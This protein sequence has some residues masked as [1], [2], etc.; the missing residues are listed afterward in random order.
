MARRA[1]KPADSD[2]PQRLQGFLPAGQNWQQRFLEAVKVNGGTQADLVARAVAEWIE[3]SEGGDAKD[4]KLAEI[5]AKQDALLAEIKRLKAQAEL[6]M[7]ITWEL[8]GAIKGTDGLIV[9][10]PVESKEAIEEALRN[11]AG[12]K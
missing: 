10:L 8:L 3:A 1:S 7:Y 11:V 2:G 9:R 12:I 4:Q 6:Q 5:S